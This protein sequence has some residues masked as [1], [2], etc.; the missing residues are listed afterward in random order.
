MPR[1]RPWNTRRPG[2]ASRLN[3]SGDVDKERIARGDW[4]LAQRRPKRRNAFWW[5]WRR[6]G[7]IRHWQ[8][9]HLHHAASHITGRISLL[10][11]GLAELILDRPLW[12][13]QNDR[14]VLRD[15]GAR[16]TLGA[17]RV[18]KL[19]AP[20]RG[21]RQPDYLAWLQALAQAQD[22]AQGAGA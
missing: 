6:I 14:L 17:A 4:L 7:P 2:S 13:A 9:L 5:R 20:K 11:D 19:N 18:L 21:K 15:I 12:L 16:Q 22:D 10:N 1:I 3:I 8:P